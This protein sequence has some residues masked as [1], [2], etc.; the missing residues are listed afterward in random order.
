MSFYQETITAI[1]AL[2]DR[3]DIQAHHVE[4]FMRI[5]HKT[6]D[7]LSHQRFIDEV[8]S[9]VLCIEEAGQEEAEALAKSFGLRKAQS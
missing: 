2:M 4:A 3:S 7:G 6:L 1:L 9:A 8:H 5:E